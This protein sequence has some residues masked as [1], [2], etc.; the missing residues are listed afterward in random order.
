[1]KML[2]AN[3]SLTLGARKFKDGQRGKR[4]VALFGDGPLSG[5]GEQGDSEKGSCPKRSGAWGFITLQVEAGNV[6][7]S[8]RALQRS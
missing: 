8:G 4:A 5:R 2:Q 6:P 3:G 1:M 7:D